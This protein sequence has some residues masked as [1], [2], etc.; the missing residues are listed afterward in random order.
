MLNLVTW[1]SSPVAMGIAR[2]LSSFNRGLRRRLILRHRTLLS[3]KVVKG[4]SGLLS[5]SGRK[6]GLFLEVQQGSQT[7]H[8]PVRGYSGTP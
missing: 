8:L 7:S 1:G 5:S 4:V 3:S 6:L 2:V